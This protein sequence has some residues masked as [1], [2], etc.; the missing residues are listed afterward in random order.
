VG[1]V[2]RDVQRKGGQIVQLVYEQWR[3]SKNK[4]CSLPVPEVERLAKAKVLTLYEF[5]V[6]WQ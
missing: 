3:D 6:K 4:L 1:H 2:V 5:D